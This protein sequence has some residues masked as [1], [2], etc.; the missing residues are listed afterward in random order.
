M[1]ARECDI[2]HLGTNLLLLVM[3]CND[4]GRTAQDRR[5]HGRGAVGSGSHEG[6]R[7]KYILKIRRGQSLSVISKGRRESVIHCSV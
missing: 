1:G 4:P 2:R 3:I 7:N 6:Q 5:G